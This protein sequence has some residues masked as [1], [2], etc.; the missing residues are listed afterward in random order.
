M[1]FVLDTKCLL[2][3]YTHNKMQWIEYKLKTALQQIIPHL[4]LVGF[5]HLILLLDLLQKTPLQQ[6]CNLN[7]C[8]IFYLKGSIIWY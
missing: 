2:K 7:E 3:C 6:L 4:G 5:H 8:Q 1:A